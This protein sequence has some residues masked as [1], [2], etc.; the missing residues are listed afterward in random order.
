MKLIIDIDDELVEA[1]RFA[2]RLDMGDDYVK[3]I[4]N[5]ITFDDLKAE[6]K[7]IADEEQKHDEK[8]AIGLRYAVKII[9]KY[10]VES[11]KKNNCSTCANANNVVVCPYTIK[12][13]AAEEGCKFWHEPE[14]SE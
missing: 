12:D 8:W 7:Q 13:I 11:E 14:R 5:G 10:N 9:D 6:I 1:A 2:V 3:S 4:A